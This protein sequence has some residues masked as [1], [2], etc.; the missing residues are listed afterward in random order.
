M[1]FWK[2][3]AFAY[4]TLPVLSLAAGLQLPALFSDNMVLQAGKRDPIWGSANPDEKITIQLGTRSVNAVADSHGKWSAVLDVSGHEASPFTITVSGDKSAGPLTIKNVIVG[5]VW[6]ASGQSN[7]FKPVGPGPGMQPNDNWQQVVADSANPDIRVFTVGMR[8][9]EQPIDSLS[10]KWEVASPQTTAKFTAAGYFFAR[11]LNRELHV[12]VGIIHTSWGGTRVE[13]WIS[14]QGFEGDPELARIAKDEVQVSANHPAALTQY[15]QAVVQWAQGHGY[16][17]AE[18]LAQ[19]QQY[20]APSLDDS[21]WQPA[22]I[23]SMKLSPGVR[24]FRTTVNVPP[25]WAGRNLT[26]ALGKFHGFDTVYYDGTYVGSV[27]MDAADK[28]QSGRSYQVP[29]KLVKAGTAVVAI[30][31]VTQLPVGGVIEQS[32][33]S[34]VLSGPAHTGYGPW[35]VKTVAE[36]PQLDAA[37]LST[38]PKLPPDIAPFDTASHLFNAMIN[39]LVPY[40]IAGVIWYQGESNADFSPWVIP[41]H[42]A[43]PWYSGDPPDPSPLY[44]KLFPALINDWRSEWQQHGGTVGEFPFY[45]CQ[46]ANYRLKPTKP[47]ESRWAEVRE[48]QRVTLAAVKQTGMAVL[49]DIGEAKDIHPVDKED[50]GARLARWALADTYGHPMEQSGPLYESMRVEGNK[51]RINFAHVAGGLVARPLPDRYQLVSY[52]PDSVPLVK[53]VPNSPLQGFEIA[54]QDGRFVWADAVIDGN[55]VVVSAP[56]VRRPIAVRYAW[57]DNPTCNLYNAAK[58]PASPFRTDDWWPKH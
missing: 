30:R 32:W 1:R 14:A 26:L 20:S 22:P 41:A 10:G 51:I 23:G 31:L 43:D 16:T 48:S 44:R 24:W 56:A 3:V 21:N 19:A 29:A 17:A 5:E 42:A 35:K 39:P 9:S 27:P 2:P 6:L 7:M 15:N 38:Y 47:S 36:F 40:S 54:G 4:L 11:D 45:Y 53:P 13:P 28:A 50:V 49:I 58:L 37:T 46:I 12:P 57:A 8:Q 25:D 33:R 52:K 34:L 18:D 55:S